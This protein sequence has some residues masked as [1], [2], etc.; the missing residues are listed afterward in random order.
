MQ[1][2]VEEHASIVDLACVTSTS[3]VGERMKM[4][5]RSCSS[6]FDLIILQIAKLLAFTCG[7]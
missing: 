1:E 4:K 3:S 6:W 7:F 2:S 5:T